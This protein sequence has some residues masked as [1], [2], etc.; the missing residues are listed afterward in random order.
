MEGGNAV[1]AAV[2]TAAALAVVEP[3]S[4]G[5][6]GDAFALIWMDREKQVRALNGSGRAPA[7]ASLD[8]VLR[9]GYASIPNESFP[10]AVSVPGT[11][12]AWQTGQTTA[13]PAA[14]P[15][16]WPTC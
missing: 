15:C 8:E 14:A 6:G 4:T 1:D 11:V 7:A 3:M 2:A 12:D 16:P 13:G 5:I 9:Q 10:Y